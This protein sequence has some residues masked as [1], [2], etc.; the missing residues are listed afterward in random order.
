MRTLDSLLS[1]NIEANVESLSHSDR[2]NAFWVGEKPC[3]LDTGKE[4]I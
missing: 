4:E 3:T 2:T 1:P